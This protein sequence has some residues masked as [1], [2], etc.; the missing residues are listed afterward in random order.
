MLPASV[1]PPILRGVSLLGIS[2][3]NCP[4]ELHRSI[5]QQLSTDLKPRHL[6]LIT[7]GT[8][9]FDELM[10]CFELMPDRKTE[11]RNVVEICPMQECLPD[12]SNRR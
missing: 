10:P 11:E 12:I 1:M 4:C 6:D 7:T 5:W 8:I 9:Q 3:T 2:S